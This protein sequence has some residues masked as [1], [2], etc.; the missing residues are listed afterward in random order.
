MGGGKAKRAVKTMA[1]Q[2]PWYLFMNTIQPRRHTNAEKSEKAFIEKMARPNTLK[3]GTSI[4]PS[5]SESPDL[6]SY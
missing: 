3:N 5:M 4:N 2:M 1:A 6:F